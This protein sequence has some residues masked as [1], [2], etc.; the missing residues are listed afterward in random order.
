MPEIRGVVHLRRL[1]T[2]L[3]VPAS[4]LRDEV[5]QG[6]LP[7]LRAGRGGRTILLDRETVLRI[8]RERAKVGE[9]ADQPEE[10]AS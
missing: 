7:G 8:L 2:E 4:W 5:E 10:A 1:A 9:I 6:R 3:R